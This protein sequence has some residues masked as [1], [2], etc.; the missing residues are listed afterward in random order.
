MDLIIE[1][2]R[3]IFDTHRRQAERPG[4]TEAQRTRN[5]YPNPLAQ[6]TAI[7]AAA[8]KNQLSTMP[9]IWISVPQAAFIN[10]AIEFDAEV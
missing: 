1:N 8:T 2:A 3:K 7:E 5:C 10:A 9:G 6:R 4:Y